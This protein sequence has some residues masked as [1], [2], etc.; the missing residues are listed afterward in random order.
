MKR[1]ETIEKELTE[2]STVVAELPQSVPFEVLR[3]YFKTLPGKILERVRQPAA[4][5]HLSASE[6]ILPSHPCWQV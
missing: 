1:T 2:I 3:N 4:N 6:E 5:L